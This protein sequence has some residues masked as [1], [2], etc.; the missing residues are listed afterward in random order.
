M[1]PIWS[2][3]LFICG[4][5]LTAP[6]RPSCS[7]GVSYEGSIHFLVA[8]DSGKVVRL[9]VIRVLLSARANVSETTSFVLELL[10][11]NWLKNHF[12]FFSRCY[13]ISTKKCHSLRS[14]YPQALVPVVP[15]VRVQ[16]TLFLDYSRCG[17]GCTAFS[18]STILIVNCPCVYA[19]HEQF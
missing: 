6:I 1:N 12:L 13:G 8:N 11:W 2:I 7:S 4:F 3:V 18:S 14:Y 9:C 16:L 19:Y 15:Q 10:W 5:L 17:S